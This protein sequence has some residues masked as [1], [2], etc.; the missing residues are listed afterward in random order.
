M[1]NSIGSGLRGNII[2]SKVLNEPWVDGG[3]IS[4]P[5]TTTSTTTSTT[6]STTTST[7]RAPQWVQDPDFNFSTDFTNG[8]GDH[9][10]MHLVA[11]TNN[12]TG[13]EINYSAG[14]IFQTTG[15]GG[16]N[17]ATLVR[18]EDP[19]NPRDYPYDSTSENVSSG[20]W[21]WF[22]LSDRGTTWEFAVYE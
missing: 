3:S 9:H 22:A 15:S 6:S 18:A 21:S 7:T 19:D 13:T 4:D 8:I 12:R 17:P 5:T 11:Y 20:A 16:G 10:I 2:S 14:T 1:A